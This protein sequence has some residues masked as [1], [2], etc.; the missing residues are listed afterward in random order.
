MK[1]LKLAGR[2]IFSF[3]FLLV[4]ACSSTIN[5]RH[6]PSNVVLGTIKP[7]ESAAPSIFVSSQLPEPFIYDNGSY[8]FIFHLN[9]AF[10]QNVREYLNLRL[11]KGVFNDNSV[12]QTDITITLNSLTLNQSARR[13]PEDAFSSAMGKRVP[14]NMIIDSRLSAKV[15]IM[16]KK[17]SIEVKN[18]DVTAQSSSTASTTYD[19]DS[20]FASAV[21]ESIS[22]F[23]IHLDKYLA[24]ND[25]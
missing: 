16:T 20:L 2:I 5:L 24:S 14:I 19:I 18:I 21:E 8:K 25:F 3:S 1:T 9:E 10:R 13:N 23:L 6:T 17:G 7:N 22:K 4:A 12:E 15:N 11:P